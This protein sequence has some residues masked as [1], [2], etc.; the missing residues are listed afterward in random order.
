M[1][2]GRTT[3]SSANRSRAGRIG[4]SADEAA[5]RYVHDES[6]R[7]SRDL[8]LVVATR[9]AGANWRRSST[10]SAS[11]AR[12]SPSTRFA[13]A[14]NGPTASRSSGPRRD[15]PERDVRGGRRGLLDARARSGG[16]AGSS[17]TRRGP[18]RSRISSRWSR[19]RE[20]A[21][22][23]QVMFH[24][25]FL[26]HDRRDPDYAKLAGR[27]VQVADLF[28]DHG[29]T[30]C[31]ETGQEEAVSLR[32]FLEELGKPNVGVNFDPANLILYDKG[33]PIA[34]LRTLLPMSCRVISRTPRARRRPAPGARKSSSAQ[35][36]SIGRLSSRR[37]VRASRAPSRSNARP[38]H[39]AS[40]TCRPRTTFC[41]ASSE[42]DMTR[43][44]II[45]LGFMGRMH[46]SAY[47]KVAGA[48][49]RRD[50]RSGRK[51]G[52]RRLLGRSGATSP[53]PPRHST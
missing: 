53:A 41:A 30:C 38:A 2:S 32:G 9:V 4:R 28:A 5:V 27:L 20:R 18:R 22:L 40:P 42:T 34:G 10:P 49:D 1:S 24:A 31:L 3:T 26:P 25:G 12:S 21:G 17:P 39:S 47:G 37:S 35:A 7:P 44:G 6:L 45:G 33:D 51:A 13:G 16:R 19:W 52:E 15:R 23:D 11:T 36:K 14:A 46:I 43:V 29:L 50:C 8:Q 48:Q